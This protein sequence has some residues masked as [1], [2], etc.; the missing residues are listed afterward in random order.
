MENTSNFKD[1]QLKH[2]ARQ[3]ED[4]REEELHGRVPRFIVAVD[5]PQAPDPASNEECYLQSIQIIKH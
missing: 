4:G 3:H 2:G 5:L 1:N